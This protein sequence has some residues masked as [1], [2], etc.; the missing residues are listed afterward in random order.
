MPETGSRLRASVGTGAKR[1]TAYQVA[2]NFY[3]VATYPSLPIGTDLAPEKSIG[4]DAGIDQTL[5]N[6]RVT[7]S[8][9]A[10]WTR[11]RDLLDFV[12]VSSPPAPVG[13]F[14]VYYENI[15]NAAMAG[16]ELSGGVVILP[17]VLEASGGY[18]YLDA[19]NLDTG[20]LLERRP[21][22]SATAA[23]TYTGIEGFEA[24]LSAT[25]VGLRFNRAGEV[26]PL[27]PYTR[28]DLALAY[29]IN[30]NLRFF[31]RIEN[32]TNATYQDPGG[33]NNAGFSVYA[34]LKW[35]DNR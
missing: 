15:K 18:T 10:F 26:Q 31:G 35:T 24:T 30:P 17:G 33:Y 14:D 11:F 16:V 9:T 19:R 2:N 7:L 13:V 12:L 29:E 1:P 23:F 25:Y 28:L 20:K 4:V 22:H 8:A 32:L 27:T 3:A 5:F 21:I 34:G 6:G